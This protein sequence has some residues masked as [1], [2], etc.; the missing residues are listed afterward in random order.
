MNNIP[1]KTGWVLGAALVTCSSAVALDGIVIVNESVAASS[2]DAGALKDIYA[3]KTM[4]WGGGQAIVIVVAGDKTDAAL[5]EAS[6][7]G[8]SQFKT[9]WQ[10]LDSPAAAS[11]PRRPTMSK[12]PSP[13]SAAPRARSPSFP[14]APMPRAS[15]RSTSSNGFSGAVGVS[16]RSLNSNPRPA[17]CKGSSGIFFPRFRRLAMRPSRNTLSP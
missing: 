7:M 2:L 4:Y 9:H 11:R 17:G 10:R 13:S 6:G 14:P 12:R 5:Q 16:P 3:G 1:W 8:A 15:R